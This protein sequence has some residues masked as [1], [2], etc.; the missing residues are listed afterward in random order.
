MDGLISSLDIRRIERTPVLNSRLFDKLPFER[1]H[2]M[3]KRVDATEPRGCRIARRGRPLRI[4]EVVRENPAAMLARLALDPANASHALP[5]R[6]NNRRI[7]YKCVS[8]RSS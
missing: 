7:G 3:N 6:P 4:G 5:R 1:P 8:T 2:E